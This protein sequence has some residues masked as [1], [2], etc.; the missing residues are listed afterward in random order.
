MYLMAAYMT[1]AYLQVVAPSS[2][3]YTVETATFTKGTATAE[4]SPTYSGETVTSW[5]VSPSLPAGL[6][7][8]T[9]T[10]V[11]SGTP[12]A[13]ATQTVY[14][15]TAAN[16][17]GSTT[18]GLTF[19]VIDVAPSSLSY[20][21]AN[22]V[23]TKG[24]V[25]T[26]NTPSA[27]GGAVVSYSISPSLPEGLSLDT[28]TGVISGTPTGLYG[29]ASWTVTAT[30]SGG[31]TTATVYMTVN[32]VA[33]ASLLYGGVPYA[34]TRLLAI[35]AKTPSVSGGPVVSYSVSPALPAGLSLNTATGVLS[36]TPTAA[37]AAAPYTVTATNSGG[38]ATFTLSLAVTDA[39]PLITVPAAV[40]SG[41]K[42]PLTL[43]R[44]TLSS[45]PKV[46]N[47]PV[48]SEQ[49]QWQRV[50]AVYVNEEIPYGDTDRIV[51][52]RFRGAT[53]MTGRFKATAD[54]G[55]TYVMARMFI[56][57]AQGNRLRINRDDIENV[58]SL[59]FTIS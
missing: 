22:P 18:K 56:R 16:A 24:S 1:Q 5:S 7:F 3:A 46:Q 44:T 30:N 53:N 37:S 9:A 32:D 40:Y 28:S 4:N 39:T 27:S 41:Q 59:D 34:F 12:S 23:Y 52:V 13:L 11:I 54:S 45:I 20:T 29:F 31:S 8:N 50:E 55:D 25:I 19:T 48:F 2:L 36:G 17:G 15:V 10:G 49:A 58:S 6:T 57:D 33:P 14:T 51:G 35:S 47:H 43:S 21:Y 38:A 26:A 42:A